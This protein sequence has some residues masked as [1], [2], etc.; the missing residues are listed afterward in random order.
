MAENQ[1]RKSFLQGEE[2]RKAIGTIE[3]DLGLMAYGVDYLI[4]NGAPEELIE[5]YQR[6]YDKALARQAAEL[7]HLEE[8]IL[9]DPATRTEEQKRLMLE[10][11][12]AHQRKLAR[13]YIQSDFVK[14]QMVID[15]KALSILQEKKYGKPEKPEKPELTEEEVLA[16]LESAPGLQETLDKLTEHIPRPLPKLSFNDLPGDEGEELQ[17]ALQILNLS[18]YASHPE[19]KPKEAGSIGE[20]EFA[21]VQAAT[22]AYL[23]FHQASGK[24]YSESIWDYLK[25]EERRQITEIS[26]SDFF[27]EPISKAWRMQ[28]AIALSGAAGFDLNVGK[29]TEAGKVIIEASISDLK[30]NP[31]NIDDMLKGVQRAIGNL[32]DRNGGIRPIV[33]TPAQIYRAYAGL[34]VDSFVSPA[35]EADMEAAMDKLM[36]YPSSLNFKTQLERH[37]HI[38]QQADYDYQE[39]GSGKI[40][41]NLVPAQ[42]LENAVYRGISLP[43]A[44]EIYDYPSFYQYSHI[45]GQMARV[46]NR[47]LSGTAKPA[48]KADKTPGLLGSARNI[49]V[50]ENILGRILRME[51]REEHKKTFT[52]VIKV[53]DVAADCGFKLTEKTRRTLIK[54]IGLYLEELRQAGKIKKAV[55]A[56]QGRKI[57]GFTISI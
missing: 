18:F 55:E 34:P 56:K 52:N 7:L 42:K 43:V 53:E 14:T 16:I 28:N 25:P 48:T 29:K 3:F 45:I 30:G 36:F 13:K 40:K 51:E 54:N 9:A 32:I 20:P 38:K 41:R 8:S 5:K 44:Y 37:K 1:G 39:E 31:V 22:E 47:L 21:L 11:A 4:D 19:F 2:L 27:N 24:P 10:I 26:Q 23:D 50:K 15:S 57:I 46:P 17:E 35:Q 49:A 33:I 12:G 6:S